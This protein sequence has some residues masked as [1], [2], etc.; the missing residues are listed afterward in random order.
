MNINTGSKV[1][2]SD[3]LHKS[4]SGSPGKDKGL[5]NSSLGKSQNNLK[6]STRNLNPEG[7]AKIRKT[8]SVIQEEELEQ[9]KPK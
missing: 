6:S 7:E 4:N 9:T 3:S 1:K 8:D 2:R 5:R